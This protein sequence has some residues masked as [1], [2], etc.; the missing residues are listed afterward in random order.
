MVNQTMWREMTLKKVT[1]LLI[2]MIMAAVLTACG[3]T[4]ATGNAPSKGAAATEPAKK[5]KFEF[6]YS[7]QAAIGDQL[8]K[9][10]DSFN[11][12]QPNI[13][14]VGVNLADAAALSTKLQAALVAGN[15]PPLAMLATTQTGEYALS[16]TLEDL[17]KYF[18]KDE[19]SQIHEGLFGN[20]L[21]NNKLAGIPY[22]RS[23][24]VMYYNKNML[25]K[26]GLSEEG[27]KNW[28]ELRQFAAKTTDKAAGVY[29]FE[30]PMDVIFFEISVLQQG[31]TMFTEDN[32]KVAFDGPAGLNV[33]KF[34]Q[35][36]VKEGI[37][38]VPAG[39]G[40]A[41]YTPM[42]N[43][44]LSEKL[45]MMYSTSAVTASMLQSTK[46]KFELGVTI[47][48]AGT[49]YGASTNGYNLAVL[50]KSPEEQKKASVEFIKYLLQKDNAA[51]MSIGT[52]YI[53]DTKSAV[54]SDQIKQLWAKT[55]QY[56]AAYDQLKY[57]KARPVMKGYTEITN[58]I[59]DEFKKS[60]L[61]PSL[62]PDKVV[63]Q[64]SGQVQPL[65]DAQK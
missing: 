49:Q 35:D 40:T 9:L 14:V 27:P 53:P 47:L 5:V 62:A 56:R 8:Q 44:F 63:K 11:S 15:Q 41:S 50:A 23:T 24:M 57:A 28:D 3:G 37:M 12:S 43:E 31:G 6:W 34:Y 54:E 38:K 26:A 36:M 10:V 18:S 55:P 7:Q 33:V 20:A 46:D 22:N 13:E 29:G 64:L 52:G 65:L 42:H 32:K 17:N 45:A 1:C 16:G 59:Q 60:L 39:T 48:P 25:R 4:A 21:I 61:D 19:L 58:K 30:M 51:Q 2:A